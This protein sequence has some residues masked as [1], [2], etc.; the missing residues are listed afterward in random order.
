VTPKELIIRAW[1]LVFKVE[2]TEQEIEESLS[3]IND[4][5]REVEKA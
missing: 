2:P 4:I 5:I 1:K 3:L